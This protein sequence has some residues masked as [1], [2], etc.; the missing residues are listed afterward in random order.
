LQSYAIKSSMFKPLLSL[1]AYVTLL[2]HSAKSTD[3][4]TW[5][6]SVNWNWTWL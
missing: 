4:W 1:M 2:W 6:R 3:N 5:F